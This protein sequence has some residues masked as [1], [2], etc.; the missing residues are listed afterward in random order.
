MDGSEPLPPR[1]LYPVVRSR[2]EVRNSRDIKRGAVSRPLAIKWSR[3]N[4]FY[5]VSRDAEIEC[6]G[7]GEQCRTGVRAANAR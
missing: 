3:N 6:G 7:C 4:R 1:Y 2:S 5:A